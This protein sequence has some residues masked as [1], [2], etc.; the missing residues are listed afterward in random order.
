MRRLIS[1]FPI[2]LAPFLGGCGW[3]STRSDFD[4]DPFVMSHLTK[5]SGDPSV[6]YDEELDGKRSFLSASTSRKQ[7][8]SLKRH[9]GRRSAAQASHAADYRWIRGRLSRSK[10]A[11]NNWSIQY[12][13][14]EASD[15]FGGELVLER[16]PKLGLLREGDLVL[17][18]GQL[19]TPEPGKTSYRV[20]DIARVN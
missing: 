12:P 16:T 10:N 15:A 17:L 18:E 1:T 11:P 14:G 3:I 4:R 7:N 9:T 6:A 5:G 13:H 2:L 8:P 19:V 20:T